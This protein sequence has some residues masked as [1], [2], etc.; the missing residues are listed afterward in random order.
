MKE[1]IVVC[2]LYKFVKL[3]NLEQR[4][5][6]L[7]TQLKMNNV[8]GT[9]LVAAEGINGTIAG[10]AK[11]IEQVLVAIKSDPLFADIVSKLSYADE[12]PFYRSKVK[13]KRAIVTI[14]KDV[15]PTVCVGTYIKPTEW[16]ELISR[17]DVVLLDT[18]NEYEFKIGTFKNAINPHIDTFRE[19]PD[20]VS[21]NLD[22]T[23]HKK[24]AMF[25]TGG[26]RCEKSTSLLL[27]MGFEEIYHLEG[28][29]LK[30][31]EEIPNEESMWEGECFVFDNRVSVDQDLKPGKYD[32]CH[33]CRMPI[34]AEEK[35]MESYVH[36]LSCPYCAEKANKKMERFSERQRQ[37]LLATERGEVHIGD[38]VADVVVKNRL[39]K[40]HRK[41]QNH[42]QSV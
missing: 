27:D 37:I 35:L 7:L 23:K 31:F 34:T 11:G 15:D 17:D 38:E 28:G 24:V 33:A 40:Q 22:T 25:C 9:L 3:E 1:D 42:L 21:E 26:I 39:E 2:A 32:L 14:G 12:Q 10:S 20:Y 36:G 8:K 30:Y 18:R 6:F 29:I 13:L 16:N 4:K 41:E 5:E 19:F